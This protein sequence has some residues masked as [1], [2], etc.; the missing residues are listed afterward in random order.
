MIKDQLQPLKSKIIRHAAKEVSNWS[1][2]EILNFLSTEPEERLY[3][4][5]LEDLE[6]LAFDRYCDYL[7]DVL[8]RDIDGLQ[9]VKKIVGYLEYNT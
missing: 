4:S 1:L 9:K 3:E 2:G 8:E 6:T 7:L 5:K